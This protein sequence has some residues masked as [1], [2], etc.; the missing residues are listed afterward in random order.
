MPPTTNCPYCGIPIPVPVHGH[1][2]VGCIHCRRPL[3]MVPMTASPRLYRLF[4]LFDLGKIISLPI[5]IIAFAGAIIASA[6]PRT[7]VACVAI[8]L[9]VFGGLDIVDGATGIETSIDKTHKT[10]RRGSAARRYATAKIMF[11]TAACIISAIG[12]IL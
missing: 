11:G 12:L 6:D 5:F 10:V 3:A 4:S 7:I 9:L 1:Y 8:Y 2:L